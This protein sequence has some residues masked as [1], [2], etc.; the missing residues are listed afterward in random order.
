MGSHDGEPK[1]I[2]RV[3]LR[4]LLRF[5]CGDMGG[6]RQQDLDA[7]GAARDRADVRGVR[8]ELGPDK[9][10]SDGCESAGR[11]VDRECA[12]RVAFVVRNDL[13]DDQKPSNIK[14]RDD[15][16]VKVLDFGLAKYLGLTR[17]AGI[18]H[19]AMTATGVIVGSVA[20]A[21]CLVHANIDDSMFSDFSA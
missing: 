13:D 20:L 15:G 4:D 5:G 11:P 12:W 2:L 19:S 18:D 6:D 3:L 17:L 10:R 7:A 9:G 16:R 21:T 8:R 1:P 14:L